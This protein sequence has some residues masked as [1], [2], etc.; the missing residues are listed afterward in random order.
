MFCI[1]RFSSHNKVSTYII[2]RMVTSYTIV[3]NL[4]APISNKFPHL[5]H[6]KILKCKKNK[7]D[8]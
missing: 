7:Y 2:K 1:I 3:Y 6:N 4:R 5:M 8:T